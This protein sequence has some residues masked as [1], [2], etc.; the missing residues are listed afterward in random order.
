MSKALAQAIPADG[1]PF[2]DLLKGALHA[3]VV[4]LLLSAIPF[5]VMDAMQYFVLALA[6]LLAVVVY[7]NPQE[8]VPGGI[9]YMCACNILL[10][11][12]T[13]YDWSQLSGDTWQMYY[14][15][16]GLLIVTAS[17]VARIG[18]RPLFNTPRSV[19]AF[20]VA[21]I[22]SGVVGFMH[23]TSA[24]YVIRQFYGSL[25]LTVYFAIA[26][27]I[28]DE[29]FFIRRLRTYGLC[30]ALAFV[31]YYFA[32]FSEYGFH[33]EITTLGTLMGA[34]ATLCFVKGIEGARGR[35]L[36]PAT[37]LFLV[38]VLLFERRSL[39]TFIVAMA[40]ALALKTR[41]IKA[42]F[43]YVAIAGLGILPAI[44]VD[45]A[46][47]VV[48][49][50][51]NIRVVRQIV[52][53]GAQN[54]DSL[55]DR[56]IQLATSLETLQKSPIWGDGFGAEIFWE[57]SNGSGETVEQA[58]IDNGWAYLAVKM[59]GL[60]ILTFGWF[61]VTVLRSVSR[62]ALGLSACL[63]AALV[64]TMFSEPVFFNFGT[65]AFF[66]AMAGLLCAGSARRGAVGN[67]SAGD[68]TAA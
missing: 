27:L 28:G 26:Y 8:V 45:S 29:A 15:A 10:P 39:V 68:P 17:A 11:S 19:K 33:K 14:W 53:E 2:S 3:G 55:M 58:Y 57:R 61:L 5:W 24:S 64:V 34:F 23:G 22:L 52:P 38:P 42:R 35:W 36:L 44:F 66:G 16:T 18:I 46:Q 32:E 60:G 49:E 20:L 56:A 67:V 37:V 43:V 40:L 6:V 50:M 48:E 31:V 62:S 59:G 25:L 21:A 1:R 13:R 12:G 7:N 9:L 54:V 47:A 41:S 63:I 65:S 4:L 30:C 51:T